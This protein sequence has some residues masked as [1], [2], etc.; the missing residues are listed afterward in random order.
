MII[1]LVL[2]CPRTEVQRL[3]HTPRSHDTEHRVEEGVTL[4]ITFVEGLSQRLV[5]THVQLNALGNEG[6]RC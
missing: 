5:A 4:A 1:L 6:K 2:Q 3:H